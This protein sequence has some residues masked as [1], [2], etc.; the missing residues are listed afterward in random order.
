MRPIYL[1]SISSHP[2]AISINSLDIT[3]LQ[4]EI[5]FS[6]YDYLI[7]TSKQSVKALEY[8]PK[9][10]YI[11]LPALCISQ[12]SAKSFE[13]LGGR[14]LSVGKGYGDTLVDSIKHYEKEVKWLYLRA[15]IV[16]SDFV[17][18]CQQDG[19]KIDEVIVYKS[20]C[21]QAIQE[22]QVSK[23]AI[24]IF[25]SP[26]SVECFLK[27]HT[28][29]AS[30]KIVVIGKTTAKALPNHLTCTVAQTPTILSCFEVL[31]L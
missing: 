30:Q 25:T 17:E 4:P 18:V 27:T 20:Q 31:Q 10:A 11:H 19:H 1:F 21:S 2:D 14:V 29:Y 3:F 5:D 28:L 23:D 9:E 15:K 24:L 26:S 8:Y 7:I 16:A 6:S 13:A 22:V 12:Q